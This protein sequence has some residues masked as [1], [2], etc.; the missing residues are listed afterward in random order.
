MMY[1]LDLIKLIAL[2][3]LYVT[4]TFLHAYD[5]NNDGNPDFVFKNNQGYVKTW[6]MGS[7]FSKKAEHWL[8]NLGSSNWEIYKDIIDLDNDG[9]IDILIQDSTTGYIKAIQMNAFTKTALKWITNPGGAEWEIVGL[10]DID[11]NGYP[12]IIIQNS[13][14]GYIKAVKLSA[15]FS[16]SQQWIGNPGGAEWVVKDVTDVDNNNANAE[17]KLKIILFNFI[18][19][20]PRY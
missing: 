15:E 12:D 19:I 18:F 6:E 17:I 16:K 10:K 11:A 13:T 14:N 20:S 5:F 3:L 4:T 8:T 9:D 2:T 1:L 7:S